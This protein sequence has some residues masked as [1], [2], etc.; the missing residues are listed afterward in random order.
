M[1]QESVMV[2][3]CNNIF[4]INGDRSVNILKAFGKL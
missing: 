3:Y 1:H 2:D 4:I